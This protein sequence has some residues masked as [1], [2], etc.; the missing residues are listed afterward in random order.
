VDFAKSPELARGAA[1]E[2]MENNGYERDEF[3]TPRLSIVRNPKVAL[4]SIVVNNDGKDKADSISV[5]LS[6]GKT[7]GLSTYH[8]DGLEVVSWAGDIDIRGCLFE[9]P[10]TKESPS[11]IAQEFYEFFD[12]NLVISTASA[13]FKEKKWNIAVKNSY[14][15]EEEFQNYLKMRRS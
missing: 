13:V 1:E 7:L 12:S 4:F 9:I 14:E 3:S 6:P 8:G 5:E 2:I 10:I 15:T 11:E